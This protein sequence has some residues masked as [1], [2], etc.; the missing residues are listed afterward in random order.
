MK[1]NYKKYLLLLSGIAFLT[2]S[3]AS[4][5]DVFKLTGDSGGGAFEDE[6]VV[7]AIDTVIRLIYYLMYAAG[8]IFMG[9]GAFKLKSGDVPGFSKM[10]LGGA[11]L[12]CSPLA[13][14]ALQSL[15]QNV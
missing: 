4:A 10:F 2:A 5:G 1:T 7:E 15:G 8:A 6:G 13:I 14:Q 12:F 11:A 3:T 9:I